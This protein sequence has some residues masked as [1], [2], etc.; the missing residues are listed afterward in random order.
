MRVVIIMLEG[1]DNS[2]NSHES[3]QP[4][5][6]VA[7]RCNRCDGIANSGKIIDKCGVCGGTDACIDC[8]GVAFGS[9]EKDL[10]GVCG[11]NG[12]S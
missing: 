12:Q 11:G 4:G 10:C 2:N 9:F 6:L 5:S 8:R 7:L 3:W 1:T